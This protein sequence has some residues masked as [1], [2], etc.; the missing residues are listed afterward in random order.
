MPAGHCWIVSLTLLRP[1]EDT[2]AHRFWGAGWAGRGSGWARTCQ[3]P[4][5]FV[6]D[7]EAPTALLA[8]FPGRP[9]AHP[10]CWS[11]AVGPTGDP[12]HLAYLPP[13]PRRGPVPCHG[14]KLL[15][16][17]V[18]DAL[19]TAPSPQAWGAAVPGSLLAERT[20]VSCAMP[21]LKGEQPWTT[22]SLAR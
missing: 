18:G 5:A 2:E 21:A 17:Q 8:H 9:V 20:T 19:G 15:L 1:A 3:P 22:G 13:Q 14:W 16:Q 4:Y 12:Q 10:F 11:L 7:P 6:T